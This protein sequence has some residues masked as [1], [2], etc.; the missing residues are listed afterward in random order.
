VIPQRA[1]LALTKTANDTN[2]NVGDDITFTL[3]LSNNGPDPAQNVS[4]TDL[5]PAGFTFVSANPAAAYNAG[6]GLWTIGTIET[7]ASRMLQITATVL[8]PQNVNGEYINI[9]EITSS[10]QYDPDTLNNRAVLVITPQKAD[11]AIDKTVDDDRP[12]VGDHITFT[13]TVTNLG[14]HA[15]S[16]AEVTDILPS[17]YTFVSANPSAAYNAA[18]GIW[19]INN[20]G[21]GETRELDIRARVLPP[22]GTANE[23]LNIA[24]ITYSRQYDP[25]TSNNRAEQ[26]VTPQLADLAIAKTV[27]DDN[28]N[29][30][31]HVTFTITLTNNGPDAATNV[32]ITDSLP[33]G[34]EFV[35]SNPLAEVNGGLVNWEIGQINSGETVTLELIARVMAPERLTDEYLNIVY[36]SRSDQYDLVQGNNRAEQGITP[37]EADL[38]ILTICEQ[39]EV[40]AGETWTY[41]IVIENLGPDDATNVIVELDQSAYLSR[42]QFSLDGGQTWADWNEPMQIGILEAGAQ[43]NIMLIS[44]V[45]TS[46]LVQ[47]DFIAT[48]SSEVFD[49]DEE[50]NSAGCRI[51]VRTIAD[52][53]INKTVSDSLPMSGSQLTYTIIVRNAGISDAQNLVIS[54][55]FPEE[56]VFI[57]ANHG[58]TKSGNYV[59]WYL[60]SLAAGDSLILEVL[61]EIPSHVPDQTVIIN[62]AEVSSDTEDPDDTNNQDAVTVIAQ[63]RADLSI[64]KSVDPTTAFGGDIVEYTITVTN[65]GPSYAY[66]ITIADQLPQ[67]L[68]FV[69]AS[70]NGYY[71]IYDHSIIWSIPSLADGATI[72]LTAN[73]RVSREL[74]GGIV[75]RNS[76]SVT[77]VTPP[78]SQNAPPAFADLTVEPSRELF[79]PEGFSPNGDGINDF[80]VIGGLEELYPNNSIKIFDRWGALIYEHAPYHERWWNGHRYDG[81]PV[82][83]A[84]YY[85]I[86]ELGGNEEPIRGFIYLTR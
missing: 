50:N 53:S 62:E 72:V 57:S 48:I 44:H 56:L 55:R 80:F 46:A 38:A 15:A 40:I 9:A 75:L 13:L 52:L 33:G 22:S 84:T 18:N 2:P 31:Q 64:T 47:A 24:T 81:V 8:V 66:D 77:S 74:Q 58:G 19:T 85:Y 16:H 17:G 59:T 45:H 73:L 49:P 37:K 60:N 7:G 69:S 35:S 51:D 70:A 36:I 14:T 28:P 30:N 10:N 76:V 29:V 20:L 32:L 5:L 65:I 71:I 79:I 25:D 21:V 4:V 11:L 83:R 26:G 82:P 34:L 41:E 39:E 63:A 27:D 61:T 78:L 3:T 1:D 86:L 67:G 12:N 42:T 54:D 68:T 23:Y 6:T 43:M